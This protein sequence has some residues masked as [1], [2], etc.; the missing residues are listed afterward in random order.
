MNNDTKAVVFFDLDGTLFDDDKHVLPESVAAIKEMQQNHIL[1]VIATGRNVFEIQ[2]VLDGTGIDSV[3]SANGSYVQYQGEELFQE[4]IDT[5]VLEAFTAFANEQ[6][7]PVAY[8]NNRGFALT[9]SSTDVV[10]NYQTLRLDVN[11]DPERYL[12][13]P[14][15]FM[16]VFNRDKEVMYNDRFAGELTLVRN[17][18]VCLD[19][20]KSGV[21]KRSGLE[22]LLKEARLQNVPT[23]A[24]GDQLNDLE[25]F[26]S[27]D[28]AIVMGNGN[29]K[30]KEVADFITTSNTTDGIVNGL[31]HYHLIASKR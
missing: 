28:N 18:R 8:Y 4:A 16:N 12:K 14:I 15:N 11:I 9:K 25:M 7:D 20:M 29:P 6:G 21:T 10:N 26:A 23:Y 3:V 17:N 27:V 31:R 30:D 22:R 24:F 2:Y 19:I 1:P 13:E 5:A